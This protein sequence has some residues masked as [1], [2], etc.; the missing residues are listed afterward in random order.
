MRIQGTWVKGLGKAGQFLSHPQYVKQFTQGLGFTPFPGT[1]NLEVAK[2]KM[3]ELKL[4]AEN[5]YV[6]GFTENGKNFGG[7]NCFPCKVNGLPGA[8]VIPDKST[9]PE[10]VMEVIA[11]EGL[12]EKFK[13]KVGD[14]VT[15]EVE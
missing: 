2:E 8:V 1:L 4:T 10:N 15:V 14:T 7:V 11:Q 12:V 6:F 9:H 3:D 5:V 13:L